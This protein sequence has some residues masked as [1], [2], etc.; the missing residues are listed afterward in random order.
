MPDRNKLRVGDQI[1]LMF[2]PECDLAQRER[3]I[4][5]GTETSDSTATIIERIIAMDPVV[6][7][8]RIDKF[9][10]PWFEVE[11]AEADGIHYHSLII[12]VDESW[13]HCD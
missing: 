5:D 10:A 13:E 7:I 3:E 12:L 6:T 8:V 1:R 4:M 9:G 11:L 2:V